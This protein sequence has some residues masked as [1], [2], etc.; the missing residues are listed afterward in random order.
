MRI[1]EET[2]IYPCG[3]SLDRISVWLLEGTLEEN[4]FLD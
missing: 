3:L 1:R 4:N 2:N